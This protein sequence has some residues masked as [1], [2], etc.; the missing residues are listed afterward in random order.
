MFCVEGFKLLY[1]IELLKFH[2][3]YSN[4]EHQEVVVIGFNAICR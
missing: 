1:S 4:N 3:A 2:G